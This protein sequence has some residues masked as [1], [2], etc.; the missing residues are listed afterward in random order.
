[1]GKCVSIISLHSFF[2]INLFSL[3]IDWLTDWLSD[4]AWGSHETKKYV[5]FVS[6]LVAVIYFCCRGSSLI[7][8]LFIFL[9]SEFIFQPLLL[10]FG[11]YL[12]TR[13]RWL[14][15]GT[16][17][18]RCL[19]KC[20]FLSALWWHCFSSGEHNDFDKYKNYIIKRIHFLDY[21][22]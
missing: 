14:V 9:V 17:K 7:V 19:N 4:F 3:I 18:C 8:Y 21:L 20:P 2:G 11:I 12:L 1:M 15:T 22:R 16:G 5:G 6:F 13:E 10:K